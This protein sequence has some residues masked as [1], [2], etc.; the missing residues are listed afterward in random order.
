MDAQTLINLAFG[1]VGA[2][3]GWTLKRLWDSVDHLRDQDIRLAE[4]VQSIEVLVAGRYVQRHE[5]TDMELRLI[6]KLDQIWNKLDG[7][8]D[9]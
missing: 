8:A 4:K 3:A 5:L 1:V 6:A 9:K 7:K 2:F